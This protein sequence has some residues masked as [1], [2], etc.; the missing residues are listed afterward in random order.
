MR[1]RSQVDRRWCS[2]ST[3]RGFGRSKLTRAYE[4]VGGYPQGSPLTRLACYLTSPAVGAELRAIVAREDP[5]VVLIDAMFPVALAEASS[6][7]RPSAV[8]LH[9][10]LFRQLRDVAR[11]ARAARRHAPRTAGHPALPPFDE[12][13]RAQRPARLH[14]RSGPSIIRRLPGW[15]LRA[16]CRAGARGR[17]G[18]RAAHAAVARGRS[19]ADRAGE[20]QHRL[21]AAQRREAAERARRARPSSTCTSSRRPAASSNRRSCAIPDECASSFSYAAHDPIMRARGVDRHARRPRHRDARAAPRRSDGGDPGRLPAI[22]P[23]SR[24]PW[25]NGAPAERCPRMWR[26]D[27]IRAAA[28]AVL[29]GASYRAAARAR[30]E[31]LR[32]LDGAAAAADH[33]EGLAQRCGSSTLT[34]A[35]S[36]TPL[37]QNAG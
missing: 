31:A 4:Q 25:R 10:F 20:F 11:H 22:S 2:G 24:R 30:S 17:E 12:L 28:R 16:P 37:G 23:S 18:R 6:F 5:D 13:W 8:I 15:E 14:E 1:S 26:T 34:F 9:T 32:G 3:P 21:R 19:D 7:A 33:L 27:A 29:E 35:K 36:A